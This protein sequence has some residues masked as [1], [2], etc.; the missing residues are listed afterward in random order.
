ME[1]WTVIG[2][3]RALAQQICEVRFQQRMDAEHGPARIV[4]D[5]LASKF[6]TDVRS[7]KS[8]G[9]I[10]PFTAPDGTYSLT[11]TDSETVFR[12]VHA[13]DQSKRDFSENFYKRKDAGLCTLNE[14]ADVMERE[15]GEPY[16]RILELMKVAAFNLTLPTYELGSRQPV[17]YDA[18]RVVNESTETRWVDLN[19]WLANTAITFRYPLEDARSTEKQSMAPKRRPNLLDPVIDKA[20]ERAG[21]SDANSVWLVLK[22][23]ALSGEPPFT[24]S[25]EGGL[26]YTDVN[27]NVC[28]FTKDALQKRLRVRANWR[29]TGKKRR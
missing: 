11:R 4:V 1:N 22:E 29:D 21:N 12:F 9:V 25:C 17:T 15:S 14:A 6:E 5:Q 16:E 3:A 13:N 28:V 24:G 26:S 10:R 27:N 7:L 18:G 2:L 23:M 8:M 20:I 19:S